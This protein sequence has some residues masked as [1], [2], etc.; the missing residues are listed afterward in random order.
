[1]KAL[2]EIEDGNLNL[3][4]KLPR[5]DLLLKE[6]MPA[7]F[8]LSCPNCYYGLS[9]FRASRRHACDFCMGDYG[10]P[11]NEPLEL[12]KILSEKGE[13]KRFQPYYNAEVLLNEFNNFFKELTGSELWSAQRVWAR[14]IFNRQ[15]SAIIAPT[16]VGKTVFGLILTLFFAH[17]LDKYSYI[18]LPTTTLLRQIADKLEAW[19]E[20]LGKK[21]IIYFHSSL[22]K[23]QKE[24]FLKKLEEGDFKILI[25]TSQFIVRNL[26]KIIKAFKRA[27]GKISGPP[28][29]FL[30]VDDVDS[31]LRNP[32]N[33]DRALSL[34]GF[35]NFKKVREILEKIKKA[36]TPNGGGFFRLDENDWQAIFEARRK[37]GQLIVSSATGK[38]G[39]ATVRRIFSILFGFSIGSSKEG[40][41]NVVDV[42]DS[43]FLKSE[44]RSVVDRTVELV[45]KFGS[46]GLIFVS[47]SER[48]DEVIEELQNTLKEEG[49]KAFGVTAGDSR[50][51]QDIIDRYRKGEI[52]ILIGKASPYGL[53]VRGLDLPERVKYAI[54]I[55]VPHYS[56]KLDVK[57][58]P[59]YLSYV[60][61]RLSPILEDRRDVIEKVRELASQL[62]WLGKN[63]VKELEVELVSKINQG[64]K[65]EELIEE[66]SAMVRDKEGEEDHR[67][68]S[69]ILTL[70]LCL[71]MR[72]FL[73]KDP[74]KK[75]EKS[76]IPFIVKKSENGDEIHILTADIKT[77][78]QASGR[79]SRLYAGGVTKG[80]SVV[81]STNETLIEEL[82]RKLL[83]STDSNMVP[84][85]ELDIEEILKEIE[86]DRKNVLLAWEGK[87]PTKG[88][89]Q[90]CLFIVESPTKAKT[91]ASFFGRPSRRFLPG[92]VAYEVIM[93][94]YLA[95]IVAT[96]G[97]VT[98]LVTHKF[99]PIFSYV[100]G[101]GR[102]IPVIKGYKVEELKWPYGVIK[103]QGD[104]EIK[105]API[106]GPRVT[107]NSCGYTFIPYFT[108]NRDDGKLFQKTFN[109]LREADDGN[110]YVES[111]FGKTLLP[112]KC[113]RCG[114][115]TDLFDRSIMLES[116]R[117]LA[118][119]N[120][121]V[122]IGTDP[123]IEGEKIAWDL[124]LLLKHY[125]KKVMRAEF[126]EVTRTAIE[127]ALNS[128]RE[129]D[130]NLVKGQL[131]RRIED[132]WIGFYLSMKLRE[133]LD[134]RNLSAGR[135]QSPVLDWIIE[136][137]EKWK[138][139]VDY[140]IIRI[141]DSAE[142][143]IKGKVRIISIKVKDVI[144]DEKE[145]YPHPPLITDTMLNLASR[146][147]GLS[148][149]DTMR[150]AQRL[151]ETGLITYIRTDSTRVS[152]L[153]LQIGKKLVIDEFGENYYVGRN[154]MKPGMEGAHE[155][156]RPTKPLTLD[157]LKEAIERE[158]ISLTEELTSNA[159]KLYDL[160]V[161]FFMASQ[162]KG[163]RIKTVNYK[164]EVKYEQ[165]G[166]V[167]EDII[168]LNGYL[169]V[170]DR[171]FLAA[172][173][174]KM[175]NYILPI[176]LPKLDKEYTVDIT[177]VDLRVEQLRQGW[178][179]TE[180]DVVKMMKERGLGRPSTYANI[181]SKLKERQYVKLVNNR[182]LT[183]KTRGIIV[184][185][186]LEKLNK[187][188]VSEERTRMILEQIDKVVENK[189]DYEELLEDIYEEIIRD[190]NKK[191]DKSIWRVL[192]DDLRTEIESYKMKRER[193]R[194]LYNI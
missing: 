163:A 102:L 160:I 18:V 133:I 39:S 100:S 73:R 119:E 85:D 57:P 185:R 42:Y 77:Y 132:R 81:L 117:R 138:Q 41:R 74:V 10:E 126:H 114:E 129:I 158:E 166:E 177:K 187:D 168:E 183:P 38:V 64:I 92:I 58:N 13:L 68:N 194:I 60:L 104:G 112:L 127:N 15:S 103:I 105:Y 32:K 8:E 156:I 3:S 152:S 130:F 134:E 7:F 52:D 113:P 14:R 107:C 26:Q 76:K 167:K 176:K 62:I 141:K 95:T 35:T 34:L 22:T 155:C 182:F 2:I 29:D 148:A 16:G 12:G 45:K 67:I 180:G 154:W 40:M 54:F 179:L 80:L 188:M 157:E 190:Q 75:L 17:R 25:T 169:R 6:E 122:I 184:N 140:T 108:L 79:T 135:V 162:M 149:N 116:L 145:V 84:L 51:F 161:R 33:I 90:S 164:F 173:T 88:H 186:I 89:L 70:E 37:S 21:Y 121:V 53:L 19:E 193:R 124:A 78:I 65:I 46:G 143:K 47:R 178:L 5:I 109:L 115:S 192:P 11:I 101:R 170:I 1:M 165:E 56:I 144:E 44:N 98:E 43:T 20:K 146:L 86:E 4:S 189:V 49:I 48:S 99:K 128:L 174:P 110:L 106:F 93:G 120:E 172:L 24:A 175:R 36:F 94:R 151:F 125:S 72:D 147:Y 66:Y 137:Y 139:K 171:G 55:E 123:D 91:I 28:V 59:I 27:K 71:V 136:A 63:E 97:H 87:V 61:R 131:L 142:I 30:F 111:L 23:K 118:S 83:W 181:I 69:I 191:A 153:G 150:N 9:S 159:L 82:D 50:G 96:M 31:F